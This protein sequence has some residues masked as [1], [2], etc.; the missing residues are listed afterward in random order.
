ML[1]P[2]SRS[3]AQL[4]DKATY[5]L[6]TN[7]VYAGTNKIEFT[8]KDGK[9]IATSVTSF[10]FGDDQLDLKSTTVVDAKT[11]QT[12]HVSYEGKRSGKMISG[13]FTLDGDTLFGTMSEEEN[14]YPFHAGLSGDGTYAMQENNMEGI[15]L[16]MQN[17]LST[18]QFVKKYQ[19]FFPL[20]TTIGDT[21]VRMESE[22]EIPIGDKSLVCKKVTM[23]MQL[24]DMYI[25]FIDPKNN[26][27]AYALYPSSKWEA[28]LESYFGEKPLTFYRNPDTMTEP[29]EDE[30]TDQN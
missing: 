27:P 15:M 25:L 23:T 28:F 3:S 8:R 18:D 29:P 7:G 9:I 24:S 4:P 1:L 14:E 20:Y 6:F 17:F 5:H 22:R 2:I 21:D 16:L 13:D 10:G 30:Q 12:L 19:L 11:Y 26:L